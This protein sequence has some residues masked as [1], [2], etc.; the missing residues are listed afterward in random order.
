MKPCRQIAL[1]GSLLLA[2]ALSGGGCALIAFPFAAFSG[3][4]TQPAAYDLRDHLDDG[5]LVVWVRAIPEELESRDVAV[6]DLLGRRVSAQLKVDARLSVVS[7][8]EVQRLH[9]DVPGV[10]LAPPRYVGEKLGASKVL[11]IDVRDFALRDA[12]GSNIFRGRLHATVSIL[13]TATGSQDWPT[14]LEGHS[15]KYEDETREAEGGDMTADVAER[16]IAA[17]AEQITRLFYDYT[18]PE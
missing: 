14:G 7:Y 11:Y 3:P 5:K 4:Q 13:D 1:A 12:P 10:A 6:R 18:P 9:R 2:A 15:I 8:N 16:V 17:A